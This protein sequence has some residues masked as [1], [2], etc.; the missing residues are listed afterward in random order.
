MKQKNN[1]LTIMKKEFSRFFGDRK[2]AVTT[3]LLPGLMI[4]VMYSFM[5]DA[6]VKQFMPDEDYRPSAYVTN[7]PDELAPSLEAVLT[8]TVPEDLALDAQKN[9]VAAKETELAVIFP[10]NFF[11]DMTVYDAASAT[12]AAP[13]VA[14]YYNSADTESSAAYQSLL[15]VLN[16]FETSLSNKFDVNAGAETYDLASKKDVAGMVFSSMVP[17]LMMIFLFSGCMAVAPESIAGEKERG[18]IAT[19][20]VTPLKRSELAIGKIVSLSVI[21]LLS[22]IS[23]FLGT[24]LSLPKLMGGATGAMDA[25]VYTSADYVMLLGIVLSSVLIIVSMISI[26]SAMA[27]S[28]KEASSAIMPLMIV[29]MFIGIS[30]MFGNGASTELYVYLIPLYNSVQCMSGILAFTCR[31]VYVLITVG[32]NLL[33]TV[34]LIYILTRMFNS[35]NIMFSR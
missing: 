25:S 12:G 23:S 9:A 33:Y 30:S 13:N 32:A 17:M 15:A 28:V 20:L 10:E 31:P 22:G 24:M 1:I 34:G 3:L 14:V 6:I 7:L 21:A 2:M 29:V 16:G 8:V 4:Y 19:L 18:T 35:E 27:K 11:A 26:I 5:G